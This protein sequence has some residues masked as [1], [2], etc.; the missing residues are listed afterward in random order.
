M[1]V[2]VLQETVA[3]ATSLPW[4][5]L[6]IHEDDAPVRFVV[7]KSASFARTFQVQFTLDEVIEQGVSAF[8]VTAFEATDATS[9]T[10]AHPV[11][12]VRLRVAAG[13]GSATATFRVLQAGI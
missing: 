2:R 8:P 13:S 11:A 4:I 1:P 5:P 3:T 9:G 7:N 10:I 6:N 12:A